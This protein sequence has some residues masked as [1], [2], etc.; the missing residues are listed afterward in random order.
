MRPV[1]LSQI[2]QNSMLDTAFFASLKVLA[3]EPGGSGNQSQPAATGPTLPV[4]LSD[5]KLL[6]GSFCNTIPS[7]VSYNPTK[8]QVLESFHC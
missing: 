8:R 6:G 3:G 5:R 7:P 2:Q 4:P 1:L